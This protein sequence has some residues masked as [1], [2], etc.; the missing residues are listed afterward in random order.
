MQLEYHC[1]SCD[2]PVKRP[3]E[4]GRG[5]SWCSYCESF[6]LARVEVSEDSEAPSVEVGAYQFTTWRPKPHQFAKDET[7]EHKFMFIKRRNLFIKGPKGL[8]YQAKCTCRHF[9]GNGFTS[10]RAAHAQW[11]KHMAEVE[12]QGNLFP[13]FTE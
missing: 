3:S 11:E 13:A 12:K 10:R 1:P 4:A 5:R 9:K 7:P 2:R 8:S 6:L